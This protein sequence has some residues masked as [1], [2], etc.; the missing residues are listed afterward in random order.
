MG[1]RRRTEGATHDRIIGGVEYGVMGGQ[2]GSKCRGDSVG[3]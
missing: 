3:V 1:T 2:L